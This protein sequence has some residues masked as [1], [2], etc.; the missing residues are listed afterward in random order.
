MAVVVKELDGR[1]WGDNAT[2]GSIVR[3]FLI[4]GLAVGFS[5]AW[6]YTGL[7]KVGDSHPSLKGY[8]VTSR[9]FEEG[10]GK[11]KETITVT[12]NT[13]STSSR[14]LPPIRAITQRNIRTET[15]SI[16]IT[17]RTSIR[18]SA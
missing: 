7:P 17:K 2:G 16:T 13:S 18:R 11:D 4:T 9:D 15:A 3:R 1:K 6:N 10:K 14:R 5:P 8:V 12:V